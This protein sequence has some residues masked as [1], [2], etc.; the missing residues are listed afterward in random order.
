MKI[1]EQKIDRRKKYYLVFDCETANGLND[2]LIYDMGGAVVDKKGK[3]YSAF[4]FIINDIFLDRKDLMQTAY[5]AEKIPKYWNDYKKGM[6]KIK[7]FLGARKYIHRLMK[8]YNIDI[9][10]AHNMRFDYN[11]LNTTTRYLTKSSI[12]YFLPFGTRIWCTLAMAR[13]V[14]GKMPTY[15]WFCERKPEERITPRGQLKFTAEILYQFLIGDYEGK[16]KEEHTGLQDV[17]IEKEIFAYVNKQRKKTQRTYFKEEKTF[18]SFYQTP[19][20][21]LINKVVKYQTI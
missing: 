19:L 21:R 7:T 6:Y 3:V 4:S 1:K 10:I 5:Y 9:V 2:S 14:I 16:Y 17:L 8:H 13:S 12:R 18:T 15:R 11:A 20:Q